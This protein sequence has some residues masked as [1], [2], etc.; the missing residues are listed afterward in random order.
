MKAAAFLFSLCLVLPTLSLAAG[1]PPP[2]VI[3]AVK[4]ELE[5]G[6]SNTHQAGRLIEP[7]RVGKANLWRVDFAK[8]G[9]VDW[10]GSGG[11]RIML[12]AQQDKTWKAVFDRQVRQFNLAGEGLTV[13]LYGKYCGRAGNASCTARYQWNRT[14]R[15]WLPRGK[16]PLPLEE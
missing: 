13:D 11:C 1:S 2:A 16:A 12:F 10:C 14:K 8:A 3:A 15:V 7:V 4:Q 9:T 6:G 5:T